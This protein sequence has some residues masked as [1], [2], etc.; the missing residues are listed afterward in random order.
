MTTIDVV[1]RDNAFHRDVNRHSIINTNTKYL[2]T[3]KYKLQFHKA[4]L[5]VSKPAYQSRIQ[6][7]QDR[8]M[9]EL[10]SRLII[11]VILVRDDESQE[12]N[13]IHHRMREG[14]TENGSTA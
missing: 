9:E 10:N 11:Q 5:L 12:R 14:E 4:K 3:D 7:F 2:N 6:S 1:A 13:V 8:N